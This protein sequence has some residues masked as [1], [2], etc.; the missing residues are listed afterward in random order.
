MKTY[1]IPATK[2]ETL[3]LSESLFVN[4]WTPGTD[5]DPAKLATSTIETAAAFNNTIAALPKPKLVRKVR[6]RR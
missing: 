4:N 6:R 5:I 3:L 1:V 2:K